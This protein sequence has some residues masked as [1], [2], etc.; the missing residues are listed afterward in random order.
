MV[1]LPLL[2][3]R[4]GKKGCTVTGVSIAVPQKYFLMGWSYFSEI[5]VFKIFLYFVSI[6]M[7]LEK[8]PSLGMLSDSLV[9]VCDKFGVHVR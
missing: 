1:C 5:Y 4:A 7:L 8:Y 2:L 6:Q 3:Q 9:T